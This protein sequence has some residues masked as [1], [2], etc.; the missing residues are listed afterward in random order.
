[1]SFNIKSNGSYYATLDDGNLS[2]NRV[3]TLPDQSG[4]LAV[5]GSGDFTSGTA[6]TSGT[7]GSSGTSGANGSSGTSGAN[8]S[9]GTRGTSGANGSSGTSG[10]SGSSGTSGA[11]GS[12]GTSGTGFSTITNSVDNRVLTS[13]G[14]TNSANAE[15]NLTF[16]GLALSVAGAIAMSGNSE[17]RLPILVGYDEKIITRTIS[18]NAVGGVLTLDLTTANVFRITLDGNLTELTTSN[19]P[20]SG[21]AYGFTIILVG[22]GT[23]R[24]FGWNAK[25]KWLSGAPA[26]VST[27][28]NADVYSFVSVNQGSGYLSLVIAQNQAGLA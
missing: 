22:D 2:A 17:V 14:A 24:S 5:S 11:N 9:S 10:T 15:A 13:T 28:N 4:T 1:M 12:S 6:G 8:G 19:D 18:A 21:L 7:S 25:F 26:I 16:D 20:A 27:L 23:A 3:Y